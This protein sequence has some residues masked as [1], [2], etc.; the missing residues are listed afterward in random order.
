MAILKKLMAYALCD[1]LGM[2]LTYDPGT[3]ALS[4][5]AEHVVNASGLRFT[6]ASEVVSS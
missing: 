5:S 3:G 6:V 4:G 2:K 1:T